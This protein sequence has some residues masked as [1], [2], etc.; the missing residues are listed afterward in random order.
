MRRG[1]DRGIGKGCFRKKEL[2]MNWSEGKGTAQIQFSVPPAAV[3]SW[4]VRPAPLG[5]S[6]LEVFPSPLWLI[7]NSAAPGSRSQAL[8]LPSWK[9]TIRIPGKPHSFSPHQGELWSWKIKQKR[10]GVLRVGYKVQ[11]ASYSEA[12]EMTL[13]GSG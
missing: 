8:G 3:G 1:E 2:Q 12:T 7:Q 4:R 13:R 6:L 9:I 10:E 11:R 5:I